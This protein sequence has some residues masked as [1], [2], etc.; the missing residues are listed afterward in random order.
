MMLIAGVM[1]KTINHSIAKESSLKCSPLAALYGSPIAESRLSISPCLQIRFCTVI[2]KAQEDFTLGLLKIFGVCNIFTN[3][4]LGGTIIS[5][6]HYQNNDHE[7]CK[8]QIK[9]ET[10]KLHAHYCSAQPS[11]DGIPTASRLPARRRLASGLRLLW[12]G[13]TIDTDLAASSS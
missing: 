1:G 6:P 8:G 7:E 4:Q 11:I 9:P 13:K 5:H 10:T 2:F 12:T 3:L